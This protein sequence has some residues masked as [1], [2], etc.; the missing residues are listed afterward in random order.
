[1]NISL[2]LCEI[3]NYHIRAVYA[4]KLKILVIHK[5]YDEMGN[6]KVKGET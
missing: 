3:I 4:R 5:K 1:V 6:I 2:I